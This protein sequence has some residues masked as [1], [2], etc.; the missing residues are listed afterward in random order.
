M[1]SLRIIDYVVG[2]PG[3]QHDATAWEATRLFREHHHLLGDGEFVW[4]D[5]A[6]PLR[7]WCQSPYKKFVDIFHFGFSFDS[8][9][10]IRPQA[11]IPE[12]ARY[13]RHL[14]RVQI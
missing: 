10:L 9:T 2:L 13:N 8:D 6:Y 14:S 12:N 1:P 3:S 5:S 4:T 7:D 11:D